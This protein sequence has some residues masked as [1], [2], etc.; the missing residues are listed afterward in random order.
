MFKKIQITI[1]FM[2]LINIGLV[3]QY[4]IRGKVIDREN[5]NPLPGATVRLNN[6]FK[7]TATDKNGDFTLSRL[8][9][10][11]YKLKISFFGYESKVKIIEVNSNLNLEFALEPTV[12]M[13][14]EIIVSASRSNSDL[15]NNKTE[16]NQEQLRKI[17]TGQDLPYL[18]SM[19]PS[20]VVTSDAGG[21]IGYTGMRI[22][23]SDLSRI[24]V[25]L[26]G[27][28]VND[29][30]SQAV[31]FV[32][33]PDLGS[34]VDNI[35]IQRGVGTSTNGAAAFG[36]SINIKTD[37]FSADPYAEIAS[38]AG[39]Y[40]T[41][42]NSV[43]FG[44]GLLKG[45]WNFN[46]RLSSI[47]SDGYIDRASSD[48]KSAYLSGSYYGEKDIL[49]AVV[50]LG[51]EK[52]YQA[53]YGIPKDS[54]ETNR[55]YN[56]AGEILDENENIIG[57]YDNQTDNYWQN[58][59]QL[60]YA[61]EF[62]KSIKLTA[63]GFYTRGYGY[64]ENYKNAEDFAS[65]GMNDT[66]IGND[67]IRVT[68]M[69]TQKWLD[70]H[71]YGFNFSFFYNK[72]PF[73]ITV[74]GG[75]NQ[76]DGDHYGKVIWS[77]IARKYDYNR[78]WYFNK[79][80]KTEANIFAK[81]EYNILDNLTAFADLQ[82]RKINYKIEG[83]HDDLRDL[84][85]EHNF[86]FINPK[87]GLS[88]TL[89]ESNNIY[90]SFAVTNREP[91]RSVYR[92]SDPGVE[93]KPENLKDLE[94]GYVHTNTK[95]SIGANVYYMAYK[96]QLVLTGKINNVGSAIMQNVDDSYRAGIEIEAGFK[97]FKFL[98]WNFNTTLSSNKIKNF[99]AYIDDYDAWPEQK[100]EN[101]ESVDISFSPSVI[102]N[103][104]FQFIP[105]KNL[106]I[107][108]QSSYVGKQYI[109]NTSND[110]RSIDAYLV[111]NIR[112]NY[113]IETNFIKRIDFMLVLNN[114]FNEKYSSNAWVYRYYYDDTEYDMYGYYPQAE[115]N[116]MFGVNLKF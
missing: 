44:S 28:P 33:L 37:E 19:T 45:K 65:Y 27:V 84:T 79:G 12:Y 40:N 112:I 99:T 111:N 80:I 53:W 116:F 15:S 14:D 68:D 9:S 97:V 89:N 81:A 66:I 51:K 88:F 7:A 98:N 52:T 70:N 50:I 32:D 103:N 92:D 54:L 78:N 21:G 61:H 29:G 113:G 30:E 83:S 62:S 13:S 63:S 94:L 31:Y 6:T 41:F 105:L 64:Y 104:E 10:G 48:L 60:H 36:A 115:F 39:S 5:G 46:G 26:N 24:N 2:L 114:I 93:V 17:N 35:Q 76:Y 4:S 86:N 16:I 25:T 18:L 90:A 106:S 58:Y 42:K 43:K 108:L 85:Q 69:I 8:R 71:F 47:S 56:P 87:L 3:G 59:Y 100:V 91:N 96:D 20:L 95:Y 22:R 109:D 38:T 57:Y 23:G 72:L 73:K 74:G 67:T 75:W 101:H 102:A 55:T 34:S 77:Q 82:Y 49:K 1:L 11:Q 110:N 107:S